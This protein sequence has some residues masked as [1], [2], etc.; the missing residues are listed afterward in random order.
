M[1]DW[2][3]ISC[4]LYIHVS[5]TRPFFLTRS[6]SCDVFFLLCC[7]FGKK[8]SCVT[9]ATVSV[10][11]LF[12]NLQVNKKTDRHNRKDCISRSGKLW[13]RNLIITF[14]IKFRFQVWQESVLQ[15]TQ[16]SCWFHNVVGWHGVC[17]SNAEEEHENPRKHVRDC[18]CVAWR[19]MYGRF[20]LLQV[21]I[22]QRWRDPRLRLISPQSH[23]AQL[24]SVLISLTPC[25]PS[26]V[27]PFTW[28]SWVALSIAVW[29]ARRVYL[30]V[31]WQTNLSRY[32]SDISSWECVFAH[33]AAA[34]FK[35]ALILW[36]GVMNTT[37]YR[38]NLARV[39]VDTFLFHTAT[40][41][42]KSV[43]STFT[44]IKGVKLTLKSYP[45]VAQTLF[46]YCNRGSKSNGGGRS[47]LPKNALISLSALCF[48]L[49]DEK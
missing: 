4:M 20:W 1:S 27:K 11:Y 17:G 3:C 14:W 45:R 34:G 13:L 37:A 16:V 5:K 32:Q 12:N 38:Q 30:F 36:P 39:S 48:L 26:K 43:C 6:K 40:Y 15:F 31:V 44:M 21:T 41:T 7:I 9:E 35:M 24:S 29:A 33:S 23:T 47:K 22:L 10:C 42:Q 19:Q 28:L 8:T 49:P 18:F 25:P 2:M 46:W